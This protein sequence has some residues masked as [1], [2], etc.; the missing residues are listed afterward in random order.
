M[1]GF[2]YIFFGGV[3]VRKFDLS[4]FTHSI[5]MIA[6]FTFEAFKC[7]VGLFGINYVEGSSA[8]RFVFEF[9]FIKSILI[10]FPLGGLCLITDLV[11]I[12][13]EFR[14]DE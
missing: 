11:D 5:L 4:D 9:M 1:L 14:G 8:F 3:V 7:V 2:P 10:L 13:K 12:Y 6:I